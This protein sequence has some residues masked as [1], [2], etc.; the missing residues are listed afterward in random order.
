LAPQVAAI[1]SWGADTEKLRT[2]RVDLSTQDA[3]RATVS[4]AT[5]V[6]EALREADSCAAG[7]GSRQELIFPEDLKI[8]AIICDVARPR[9]VSKRVVDERNDVL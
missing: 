2:L 1:D 3:R 5:N 8:G 9:D 4:I 7:F 6:K